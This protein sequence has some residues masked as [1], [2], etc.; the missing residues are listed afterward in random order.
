MLIFKCVLIFSYYFIY[1]Y[2]YTIVIVRK[3]KTWLE[4]HVSKL[5]MNKY[6]IYIYIHINILFIYLDRG[7]ILILLVFTEIGKDNLAEK[8]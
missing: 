5:I 4:F 1:I 6:F 3:D 8:E 7:I 2:I